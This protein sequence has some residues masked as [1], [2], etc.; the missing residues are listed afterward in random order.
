VVYFSL[1]ALP[2]FGLGQSLIPVEAEGRRRYV[3]WLMVVYVAGGLGLL[4][5]T[6]F[7]G[8]RHYLRQRGVRMPAAMTGAWLTMG[9][10]LVVALLAVGA[11]L[12]RPRA[13][14]PL[15]ELPGLGSPERKASNWAMKDGAPGKGEGRPGSEGPRGNEKNEAEAGNEGKRGEGQGQGREGARGDKSGP[16]SGDRQGS[17]GGSQG[18]AEGQQDG[19]RSGEQGQG[20][21]QG[22][23]QDKPSEG[24]DKRGAGQH[25]QDQQRDGNAG[26]RQGEQRQGES[27]NQASDKVRPPSETGQPPA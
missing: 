13:E 5:T 27:G 3:F 6:T 9:G 20:G 16:N 8:L 25:P 10:V 19:G 1:A 15:V 22:N 7:L 12:P 24:Q 21:E 11:L 17:Q 23:T 26:R 2:L 14:Y 4:L 18:K